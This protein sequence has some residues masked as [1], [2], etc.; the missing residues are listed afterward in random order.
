MDKNYQKDREEFHRLDFSGKI[1]DV[2]NIAN[3][4]T[5][6]IRQRWVPWALA[7]FVLVAALV[8][9]YIQPPWIENFSRQA[10]ITF[11][12][13]ALAGLLLVYIFA[14]R[15]LHL[16]EQ[17]AALQARLDVSEAQ[18][19]EAYQRLETIF[20]LSHKFVEANDE[21]EVID[22]LL[23]LS[24]DLTGAQGGSFVPLDEHSQPMAA[25]TQGDLPA[26][27]MNAWVEYLA[28]P[29]TR[30]QC[31]SCD[32]H[33]RAMTVC[34]L[35]QGP[36]A[37]AFGMY[38][39]PLRSGEREFGVLNLY[40]R[41]NGELDD[42][43]EVF[44][45]A[46]LDET[47]LALESVRLRQR[48]LTAIRQI[49]AVR[50]KNDLRGMLT[51]LVEDI[52]QALEAD[53]A[54]LNLETQETGRVRILVGE[55]SGTSQPFLDGI[56]QGVRTSG[57]PVLLGNVSGDPAVTSGVRS[58]MAASLCLQD[59]EAIGALL[60]GNRRVQTFMLR[61]LPL[62]QT[63]SSQ[64]AL[65]VR[66]AA[67]MAE[68][69]YNTMIQERK[70][71]AREIHDGLAQTL[72]FLKLQA[73]QMQNYLDRQDLDRLRSTMTLNYATL[74]EAYQDARQAID[75]LRIGP[76]ESGLLG[77]LRQTAAEFHEVSDIELSLDLADIEIE[78]P[79]E[80]HAQLIRIVQEA[81]NNIRKHSGARSACIICRVTDQDLLLEV[82]DDGKGFSP[83]DIP[84]PSRHG[85]RGM[86]ERAELIGADFQVISLPEEG[87]TL[88]VRLP[89]ADLA[90][91]LSTDPVTEG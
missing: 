10:Q 81:L 77:W 4:F 5:Q 45:R 39:L 72:G 44:L 57:E 88:R 6:V 9:E 24:I 53:F 73:A 85:M 32:K 40:L 37:D 49:Q 91:G 62:L 22:L 36:M 56:L 33:G 89:L 48:E 66:N 51:V 27:V 38:C 13:L 74:S 2:K 19:A 7:G 83:A 78:M 15:G 67:W 20:R 84:S 3:T 16:A 80:V 86:R 12:A 46:M 50:Q 17:R 35:I 82:H 54:I 55:T 65:V 47:A 61:Q 41:H 30:H 43:T 59:E 14:E 69:E 79:S 25:V 11:W 42:K 26:P 28:S 34:P 63:V 70:R 76:D 68:L 87:T 90:C 52:R 8:N 58:L 71:L 29:A 64:V 31:G 75:G 23:K 21:S 1:R 60:V 18:V